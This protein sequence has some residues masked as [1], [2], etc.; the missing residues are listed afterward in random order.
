MCNTLYH[1]YMRTLVTVSEFRQ[2]G[3][4][5]SFLDNAETETP[6]DKVMHSH[7]AF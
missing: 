4:L 2:C 7:G 1:S 5:L 6:S 3:A